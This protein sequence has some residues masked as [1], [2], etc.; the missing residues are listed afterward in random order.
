MSE[1]RDQFES[2]KANKQVC[3]NLPY[4]REY[5]IMSDFTG[6]RKLV[7]RDIDKHQN[8]T[9]AVNTDKNSL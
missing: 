6:N 4:L 7:V 3:V 2:M 1:K 8:D 9:K 5:D